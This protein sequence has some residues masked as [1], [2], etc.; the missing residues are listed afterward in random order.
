MLVKGATGVMDSARLLFSQ[1]DNIL[2]YAGDSD[3]IS[4]SNKFMPIFLMLVYHDFRRTAN[5]I[6]V[7]HVGYLSYI[8]YHSISWYYRLL[9][10]MIAPPTQ[11]MQIFR[12][13]HLVVKYVGYKIKLY[14]VKS[15]LFQL[16]LPCIFQRRDM[17]SAKTQ[18][19]WDWIRFFAKDIEIIITIK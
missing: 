7:A 10:N 5:I 17:L 11:T 16:E 4:V 2:N 18:S 15:V 13:T 6:C 14:Q 19:L 9:I 8:N 1:P 3:G 12:I